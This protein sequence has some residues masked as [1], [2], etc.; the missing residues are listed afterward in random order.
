MTESV[1]ARSLTANLTDPMAAKSIQERPQGPPLRPVDIVD[2]T[3][4]GDRRLFLV[5][6]SSVQLRL[7]WRN[8][9]CLGYSDVMKEGTDFGESPKG[10]GLSLSCLSWSGS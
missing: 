2:M 3:R 4:L 6:G 9:L 7:K 5:Q 10:S 1:I 8:H